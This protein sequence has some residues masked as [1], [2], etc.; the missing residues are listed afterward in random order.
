[1]AHD[2]AEVKK[3]AAAILS[4]RNPQIERVVCGSLRARKP[5]FRI[6][7]AA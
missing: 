4:R 3:L 5:E 6:F 1:M 2:A 7:E